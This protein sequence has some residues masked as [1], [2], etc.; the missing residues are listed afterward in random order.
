MKLLCSDRRTDKF[1]KQWAGDK[2][3]V[4]SNFFFWRAGESDLQRNLDGL[5]RGL[6]HDSLRQ[7]TDLIPVI[8][9]SLWKA[10]ESLLPVLKHDVGQELER[11]QIRLAF[12]KMIGTKQLYEQRHFCFFI[13]GLDE[14]E[15]TTRYDYTDLV[16]L[17]HEWIGVASGSLK[18]CVSSRELPAFDVNLDSTSRLRLHDLTR[19]D[20]KAI[21]KARLSG[22][23]PVTEAQKRESD[24]SSLMSLVVDRAEGVFLWVNLVLQSLRD[25]WGHG[26]GLPLLLEKVHT[27]PL[28]LSDLFMKLL[29]SVDEANKRR[30]YQMLAVARK[31]DEFSCS[32]SALFYSFLNDVGNMS[33]ESSACFYE[34]QGI[35]LSQPLIDDRL[36]ETRLKVMAYSKGLLEVSNYTGKVTFTHRTACDFL[37][38]RNVQELVTEHTKDFEVQRAI[39][40]SFVAEVRALRD[41][42]SCSPEPILQICEADWREPETPK[43]LDHIG[44][45]IRLMQGRM[46][47]R[48]PT[49]LDVL[50]DFDSIII[51]QA[52]RQ[53]DRDGGLTCE[54]V[55][56][57]LHQYVQWKMNRPLTD[58]EAV[59]LFMTCIFSWLYS[60]DVKALSIMKQMLKSRLPPNE[61]GGGWTLC[62]VFLKLCINYGTNDWH[63]PPA[64][65]SCVI[66]AFLLSGAEPR[67]VF[68]APEGDRFQ[69]GIYVG[70][71]RTYYKFFSF[72]RNGA[73]HYISRRVIASGFISQIAAT[74]CTKTKD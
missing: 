45:N 20:I 48:Q 32:M 33:L 69:V 2:T 5:F 73:I 1:L 59:R 54:A 21:V 53:W 68:D 52:D 11:E 51:D 55:R 42:R 28:K 14:Y 27:M 61:P 63:E 26:D 57:G 13:D 29:I 38:K 74:R 66:D 6:L 70:Q 16:E 72:H 62:V 17:L 24:L 44:A 35:D 18:I 8:L 50:D 46:L 40:L 31:L 12:K 19:N 41:P 36:R 10:S 67:I 30:A 3:V 23:R 43:L 4:R 22:L 65:I 25:G 60:G 64:R 71:D 47:R 37:R 58:E 39:C 49:N 7:C 15:E 56:T 9:P 34:K